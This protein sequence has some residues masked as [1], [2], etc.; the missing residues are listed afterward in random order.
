MLR[1]ITPQFSIF[2]ILTSSYFYFTKVKEKK[3]KRKI[4]LRNFRNIHCILVPA[5]N[6]QTIIL[7]L[8]VLYNRDTFSFLFSP[9]KT[10]IKFLDRVISWFSLNDPCSTCCIFMQ[11]SCLSRCLI[12]S[13]EKRNTDLQTCISQISAHSGANVFVV[14][15]VFSRRY[16]HI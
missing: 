6:L 13:G 16:L 4:T 7:K 11:E 8:Y 5:E 1:N 12:Y 10:E 15:R 14:T 3:R 2:F 9:V